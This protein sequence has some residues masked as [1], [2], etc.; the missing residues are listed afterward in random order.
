MS[1][2]KNRPKPSDKTT[3]DKRKAKESRRQKR[4]ERAWA[5]KVSAPAMP[6]WNRPAPTR[7]P[8]LAEILTG[9]IGSVPGNPE[10]VAGRVLRPALD[11]SPLTALALLAA[12]VTAA[13]NSR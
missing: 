8:S 10:Q 4:K 9:P 7:G 13:R 11:S 3:R 5:A 1:S 12:H 6:T 2:K